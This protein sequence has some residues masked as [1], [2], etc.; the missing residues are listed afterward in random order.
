MA[1][2]PSNSESPEQSQLIFQNGLE[3]LRQGNI[4]EADKCFLDAYRLHPKNVDALNLLGIRSYQKQ[5]YQ[6]A[7]D[8]LSQANHIT[9]NSAQTLSN[10][11]LVHNALCEFSEALHFFNLA[12]QC[13][14]NIPETHNNRGN[15]LKGLERIVEAHKAYEQAVALRP[16]YSEALSNQGVLFLE[17]GKPEKAITLF[18][19]AIK[20]NP[21]FAV[22]L[23]NLGNAFTQLEQYNDAF[24][25][26]ERALQ[27]NPGYLDACLNFGNS[28]KKCKQ[29]EAAIDCY[30]HA[31]KI[32]PNNAKSFYL[33]GEIYYDLGDCALAKTYYAK[34]LELHPDDLEVQTALAIAQI[35]KVL[36]SVEEVNASRHAFSEQLKFLQNNLQQKISS[37]LSTKLI[38][39]HPFYLAYQDE[40]NEPL[41][42]Q[43][44]AICFRQA[45]AI[46]GSLEIKNRSLGPSSKIRVGI[47]SNFFCDH[48]VW[49]A[50]TKGW[51]NHLNPDQF[52]LHLF[53]TNGVEDEETQ[54]A[55]SKVASYTNCGINISDAAQIISNQDLD[56]ILYPEIGMD[57]VS[58]ALACL[59]LAPHQA[60]SWGH[61]ETTGLP[62]I[63]LY[64]SAQL[65]E[66]ADS[67]YFY[68]EKLVPLP[69]LGTYFEKDSVHAIN[70]DLEKLGI[71]SNSPILLCA[72]SPSKYSPSHDQV[73]VQIAKKLGK[74][75]LI[76][77]NFNENLTAILKVRLQEA[78]ELAQLNPD[79]FIR[80]IPFLKKEEFHSLM[81]KADLYLDT[82]GF[83]GFNT[84]MQALSYDLPIVTIEGSK[85]RGR[86]ASAILHRMQ[87]EELVCH[88]DLAYID[89]VVKL[90][91]DRSLLEV[92]KAKI[93]QSKSILFNDLE[94][95]RALENFLI[96]ETRN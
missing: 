34:S 57:L 62:T 77:F 44:G 40:N 55:K 25:C 15:A 49:H 37:A 8:F 7:I 79:E 4:D 61:P 11:G 74:C 26:F 50:I 14:P 96:Q 6:S 39:R 36:K 52:E 58:K 28:L 53:N 21:H 13:D 35:P 71:T 76:F 42:S 73:L 46:Q 59:R 78:F 90:I 12:I 72:G 38:A 1:I 91:S 89:L 16:N 9:P 70:L 92:F 23:N 81:Q 84:A 45:Q 60:V 22:A 3:L 31:L 27:I 20:T 69:N 41:L 5:D 43:F 83:S 56:V 86:L 85:M 30:Q 24:Q 75:Q 32:A 51:V 67:H 95:I 66:P 2:T 68:A 33:L 48:P 47:I 64:L 29:Y 80:F 82:I 88:S 65:M 17:S 87:L 10:L 63:D 54:L 19:R 18:D 93:A 94:P